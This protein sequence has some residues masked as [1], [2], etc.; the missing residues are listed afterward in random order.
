M[1][2][3]DITQQQARIHDAS[4]AEEIVL[5][6]GEL[7]GI[8]LESLDIAW[9]Q[10]VKGTILDKA[11]KIINP[12][13]GRGKCMDCGT[14]FPMHQYYDPCPSCGEHLI[15]VISGKEMKVKTIAFRIPDSEYRIPD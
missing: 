13:P 12:V 15:E 4:A 5:D 3:I 14:V 9:Q 6:I 7:S 11:R 2:I 10:A 1:G 8:E